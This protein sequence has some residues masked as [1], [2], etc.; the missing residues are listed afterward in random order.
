MRLILKVHL[1]CA[2]LKACR[3]SEA[4]L[5]NRFKMQEK[6]T[7]LVVSGWKIATGEKTAD[8]IKIKCNVGF[9][10]LLQN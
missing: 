6:G 9:S 3:M 1:I 4:T 8:Y 10:P 7:A 2:S 5:Q